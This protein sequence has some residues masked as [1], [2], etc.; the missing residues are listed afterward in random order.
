MKGVG[1]SKTFSRMA[2]AIHTAHRGFLGGPSHYINASNSS[3]YYSVSAS[4][5]SFADIRA[6][7]EFSSILQLMYEQNV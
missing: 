6:D 7:I 3:F 2:I 5:L 1:N 4:S